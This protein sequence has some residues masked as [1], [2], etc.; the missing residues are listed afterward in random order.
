MDK[1]PRF[2]LQL[3]ML[4]WAMA[5]LSPSRKPILRQKQTREESAG[6]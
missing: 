2:L 6:Q 1:T 4:A 3:L 5:A